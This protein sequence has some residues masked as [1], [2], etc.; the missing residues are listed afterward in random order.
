MKNTAVGIN[1]SLDMAEEKI[2]EFKN[3]T[4]ETIQNETQRTTNSKRRKKEH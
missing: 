2:N 4:T 1:G 3:K